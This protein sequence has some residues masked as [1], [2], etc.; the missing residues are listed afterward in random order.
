MANR[1]MDHTALPLEDPNTT[2]KSRAADHEDELGFIQPNPQELSEAGIA[3]PITEASRDWRALIQSQASLIEQWR[4]LDQ[5]EG[6]SSLEILA[7]LGE[8]LHE[9]P[10]AWRE[11][12]VMA[13]A[14][15]EGYSRRFHK[16][17]QGM[18]TP[19]FDLLVPSRFAAL[20]PQS[21]EV[22]WASRRP[23]G[24]PSASAG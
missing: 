6:S 14:K 15:E 20:S 11:L 22:L 1:L 12:L 24:G 19:L 3:P 4:A 17:R 10:Q 23:R 5:D 9:R 7:L 8:H 16:K 13:L 2:P 18:A 21:E